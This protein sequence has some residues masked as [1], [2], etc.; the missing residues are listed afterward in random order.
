MKRT[1][2]GDYNFKKTLLTWMGTV[3]SVYFFYNVMPMGV[4]LDFWCSLRLSAC[5]Y[6]N[7]CR[8]IMATR[9]YWGGRHGQLYQNDG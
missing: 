1:I 9:F 6:L 7:L 5:I 4:G 8:S 2:Y 3:R